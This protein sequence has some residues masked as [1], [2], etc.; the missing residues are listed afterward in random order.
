MDLNLRRRS[1]QNLWGR[2]VY[3]VVYHTIHRQM[4]QWKGLFK[5]LNTPWRPERM[6]GRL[7]IDCQVSC[8][9]IGARQTQRQIVRPRPYFWIEVW[10]LAWIWWDTIRWDESLRNRPH[11][12]S[13]TMAMPNLESKWILAMDSWSCNW[14]NWSGVLPGDC[15]WWAVDL[16]ASC[17]PSPRKKWLS[18]LSRRVVWFDSAITRGWE[19]AATNCGTSTA[20]WKA[21][22]CGKATSANR[23]TSNSARDSGS[24][25][26]LEKRIP[27]RH[28]K[29][30]A[31][32][33]IP[34]PIHRW[35]NVFLYA[36]VTLQQRQ[37]FRL[38]HR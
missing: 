24:Y 15:S 25:T 5:P 26:S 8:C 34:A 20:S 33:E 1:L 23:G 30:P 19:F 9:H 28:C 37:R 21:V 4:V 16:E 31:A 18:L 35:R 3:N 38:L 27:V 6:E 10:E 22:V 12:R 36:T 29:P 7:S 17:W 14:E 2:I 11:R 13:T 32:P